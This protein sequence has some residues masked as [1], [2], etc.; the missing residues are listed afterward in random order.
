MAL[1]TAA[2]RELPGNMQT[3]VDELSVAGVKQPGSGDCTVVS[4]LVIEPM[5]LG[6]A[7]HGQ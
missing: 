4:S 7:Y 6:N 3:C 5:W 2:A 1:Q